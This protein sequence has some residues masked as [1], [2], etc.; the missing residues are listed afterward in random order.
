VAAGQHDDGNMRMRGYKLCD[1]ETDD[2]AELMK[3]NFVDEGE[4]D[5]IFR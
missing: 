1:Y 2:E 3:E 5:N 4:D